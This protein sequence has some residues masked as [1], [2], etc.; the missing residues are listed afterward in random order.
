MFYVVYFETDAAFNELCECI[1]DYLYKHGD[2]LKTQI[3][4]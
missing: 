4:N 2:I 3:K 1:I